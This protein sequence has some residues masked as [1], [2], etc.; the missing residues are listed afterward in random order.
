MH[1][2]PH[3]SRVSRRAARNELRHGDVAGAV[4]LEA[5][6]SVSEAC[7]AFL[8]RV[9]RA[10]QGVV[11]CGSV[12]LCFSFLYFFFVF[13]FSFSLADSYIVSLKANNKRRQANF[14][15]AERMAVRGP[16]P[17]GGGKSSLE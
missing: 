11:Y 6:V 4:A 5:A 14:V 3:S 1:N 8:Y 16:G 2:Q 15:H 10:C 12:F 13:F 9:T 17:M 7:S